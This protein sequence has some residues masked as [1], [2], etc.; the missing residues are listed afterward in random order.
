MLARPDR[1]GGNRH[2]FLKP[3]PLHSGIA[4]FHGLLVADRH[5]LHL[6]DGGGAAL[7]RIKVEQSF[8]L[9]MPMTAELVAKIDG[10][11]D[12][13]VEAEAAERIVQ[14]GGVAGEQHAAGTESGCHALMHP[15]SALVANLIGAGLRHESLQRRLDAF[16]RQQRFFAFVWIDRVGQP[17][18]PGCAIVRHLEQRTPFDGVGDIAVECEAVL[19]EIVGRA[20][21]HE[22]LRPGEALELDVEAL[23]HRAAAAVGADQP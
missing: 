22:Q 13:A 10:I 23:A 12:A 7:P 21:H 20:H 4:F 15:V 11:M 2:Q 3:R 8:R 5:G 9:A 14:M 18:K 6:L 16:R 17:P 19:G 1:I